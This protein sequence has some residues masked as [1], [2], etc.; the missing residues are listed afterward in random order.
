M[1]T[2]NAPNR[3][4]PDHPSVAVVDGYGISLTVNR[5]HLVIHDGIGS[6]RRTR[7]YPRIERDLRR[8]LIL[9][10]TGHVSLEAMRWCTERN[11]AVVQLDADN[12][13]ITLTA[14]PGL[15]D[16]RLRRA[17]ARANGTDTGLR[18]AQLLL[19]TKIEQ[20][21]AVAEQLL[22]AP[23]LAAK[24]RGYLP[25]IDVATTIADCLDAESQAANAYFGGWAGTVH[26][27]FTE[28]DR[29]RVP[30]HWHTFASRRSP[31]MRGRTP[32]VATTP[33]N[34]LLNYLYALA[35][36][37]CRIALI[38]L[39]L[40]PG[41]G[42]VHV[43]AKA[44]DSLALDLLEVVR[45]EVD[46]Y[47]IDLLARRFFTAGDFHEI[48]DGNCRLAPPLAHDLA[49]TS[50]R[51]AQTVA[52]YAERVAH[53]LAES[54]SRRAR[55]T[56][57]THANRQP[58]R[59]DRTPRARRPRSDT[60]QV[61][62][63]LPTCRVCGVEL[64]EKRRQ[65]CPSCWP[66]TRA[67]L[68]AERARRG[69]AVISAGRRDGIDPTNTEPARAA[70]AASLSTRKHE[71]LAWERASHD[72]DELD[73]DR[74]HE[75]LVVVPLREIQ[76]ATGLS[77]S[78]CSRIRSGQLTPHR[79]HWAALTSLIDRRTVVSLLSRDNSGE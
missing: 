79:R 56:P 66:V 59:L 38:T 71:E 34:A 23:R 77:V 24:I 50:Q 58:A 16:A 51:W 26:I 48:R 20:Q 47:V 55:S 60:G 37:E 69:R 62:P 40:D 52:P 33:I 9:G 65:L 41:L 10:H 68:A 31:I 8:I 64:A 54:T 30:Q 42:V 13:I 25:E 21:A 17:Q 73:F 74:L 75:R 39:G 4:P 3:R 32:R 78:A 14:A 53:L 61:A 46:R 5:G 1:I 67:A 19:S 6:Q 18:I 57:L 15:D 12:K 7:R 76:Q 36:I 43:D 11:I 44:R 70:R 72:L 22:A 28:G 45:P 35:E 27:R 2:P 63:L 49:A 29:T